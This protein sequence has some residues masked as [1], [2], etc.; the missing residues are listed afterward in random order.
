MNPVSATSLSAHA[1]Y[2]HLVSLIAVTDFVRFPN[3]HATPFTALIKVGFRRSQSGV[4][5][6]YGGGAGNG[7]GDASV[8]LVT[9]SAIGFEGDALSTGGGVASG[10]V[11]TLRLDK[12]RDWPA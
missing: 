1:L 7:F 12:K 3:A 4:R 6:L 5:G 9:A 2:I 8:A 10:L 11:A